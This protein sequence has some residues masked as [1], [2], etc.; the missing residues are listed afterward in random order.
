MAEERSES[1]QPPVRSRDGGTDSQ[2]KAR[3]IVDAFHK[4]GNTGLTQLEHD[5]AAALDA[6][7]AEERERCAKRVCWGCK[8]T[9]WLE[10]PSIVSLGE[11]CPCKP[12]LS[13]EAPAAR[14]GGSDGS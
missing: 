8:G 5:F 9:G 1:A 10:M 12:L 7:R 14:E 3:E 2:R 6:A 4:R 11:E 13:S